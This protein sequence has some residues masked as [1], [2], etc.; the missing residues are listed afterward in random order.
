MWERVR[1][2]LSVPWVSIW[3]DL[4]WTSDFRRLVASLK[5]GIFFSGVL[6]PFNRRRFPVSISRV[7]PSIILLA[8]K[9]SRLVVTSVIW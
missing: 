9:V 1:P 7:S 2:Y 4:F 5:S 3:I 6:I 8:W